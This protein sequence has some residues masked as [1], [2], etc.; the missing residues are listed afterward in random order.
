MCIKSEEKTKAN[1]NKTIVIL[2]DIGVYR[3]DL[4]DLDASFLV[5]METL[6]HMIWIW[7]IRWGIRQHPIMHLFHFN[8]LWMHLGVFVPVA[9]FASDGNEKGSIIRVGV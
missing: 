9:V 8:L 2:Q 4:F 3:V 7:R 1:N 6:L 5:N